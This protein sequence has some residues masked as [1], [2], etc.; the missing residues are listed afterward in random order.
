MRTR[1]QR[2]GVARGAVAGSG[3]RSA[4]AGRNGHQRPPQSPQPGLGPT[5]SARGARIKPQ[6]RW[7]RPANA[8]SGLPW[9]SQSISWLPCASGRLVAGPPSRQVAV[10]N[11]R[12]RRGA[13]PSLG[14]RATGG[15]RER[16]CFLACDARLVGAA[17]SAT[18]PAGRFLSQKDN[19]QCHY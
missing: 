1:H 18:L 16:H 8:P 10:S 12:Q 2:P 4:W 13:S 3:M 9:P 15:F 7:A 6:P 19:D 17:S 14:G 5:G 11:S